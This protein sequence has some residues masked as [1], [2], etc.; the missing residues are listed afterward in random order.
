MSEISSAW[1]QHFVVLFYV[2][3][4]HVCL[5][6]GHFV[7][8]VV[9]VG[10]FGRLLSETNLVYVVSGLGPLVQDGA[11]FIEKI[12]RCLLDSIIA[13]AEFLQKDVPSP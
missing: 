6:N 8:C 12:P 10:H 4:K 5:L 1:Q 7:L 2:G 3:E 9:C 11:L 13:N